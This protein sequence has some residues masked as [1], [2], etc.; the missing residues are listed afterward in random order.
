[1]NRGGIGCLGFFVVILIIGVL[2]WVLAAGIWLLGG[3]VAIGGVIG[4]IAMIVQA[5]KSVG[6]ARESVRPAETIELM[7]QDCAQD[8]RKLQ[9]RWAEMAT[10]HGIGTGL[11]QALRENP[12]LADDRMRQIDAMIV[13]VEQQPLLS[14]AWRLSP[15]QK[16]SGAK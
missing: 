10:T 16:G 4:A 8:L 12:T 2:L 9:Y 3:L 1:M 11:E 14:S 6:L 15:K 13:L 5:W 7:A